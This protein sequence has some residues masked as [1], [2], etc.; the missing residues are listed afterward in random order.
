[1]GRFL[2]LCKR[3]GIENR[4]PNADSSPMKLQSRLASLGQLQQ[5]QSILH[6]KQEW[7]VTRSQSISADCP[8]REATALTLLLSSYIV[9]LG[10]INI[11]Q[12]I[13]FSRQTGFATFY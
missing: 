10:L 1:M 4:P 5:L 6:M 2:I 3:I 12:Q 8:I 7:K 9:Y 11:S 13:L